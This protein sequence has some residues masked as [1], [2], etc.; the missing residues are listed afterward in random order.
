MT[1]APV[2]T[3][4]RPL[5][6][7]YTVE[8]GT[9]YLSGMQ[10][11]VRLPL[12][13]RRHDLAAGRD[14]A[15]FIS[16]YEGSP[17]AGYDL[18][19]GR[20]QALLDEYG[21]VFMPGLNEELAANAVQGSQLAG[22]Q[23]TAKQD[24]VIGIWYGKAP[25]LDRAS[26][27]IR[28]AN[29]G[30]AHP[31]GGALVLVG[32]DSTAKS[33]T[34]PSSSEIAM[35]ELGLPVLSP[36]DP[37][38][39]LFLG[40]H[41]LAM[42]RFSGLYV[43]LKIATNVADGSATTEVAPDLVTPVIPDNKV[44][45]FPYVHE[46]SAQFLQPTLSELENSLA[47]KRLVLAARYAVA[48]GLNRTYGATG[49]ARVGIVTAGASYLD[50]RQALARLGLSEEELEARGIRLLRLGVVFPLDAEEIIAFADGLDEIVVVEEKRSF[51]ESGIKDILYGRPDAP[52][53]SGK[54]TM[55]RLPLLRSDA[56]LDPEQITDALRRRLSEH[57]ALPA[58]AEAGT[59]RPRPTTIA[60]PL[61]ARTPY[62]CSGCPHNRSTRAPDGSLVGAG[63]GC[64]GMAA[65]M[66]SDRVGEVIGLS[67]MGGEGGPWIGMSPFVEAPHLLQN[68]GDGTFHHSGSLAIRAA[69]A[70]QV[71]I[72]YKIL[73][74]SAVAMT[75]GQDA[76]G[77]MTV[78]EIV[79]E[80]LAEGVAR[81]VITTEEPHR[82]RKIRLP[83]GVEVRHR[84]RLI[85]TQQELAKVPGVT[86]LI[87]D[88]ECATELRRKRKRKL[89][90]EP[91]E[92]AFINER[93][94]EGC[95][96]CGSKSNC[97]SVQ[98]VGTEY[99]RKTAIHQASC[100]KDYSCLDGDCPSFLTVV[101]AASGN[102]ATPRSTVA[103][104]DD[105]MLPDPEL[106]VPAD[107][108]GLRITGIGGTGVVTVSQII[109]TA[110]SNSGRYV[111]TLDQTGLAQKGGAVV[112][113]VKI[114]TRPVARS[115]KIAR[116]EADLYLGCDVL[117]AAT[118]TYLSVASPERTV[119][120]VSTA[121]VPTGAMVTDTAVAFP[122]P[123]ETAGRIQA[124]VRDEAS[125]YI[126]AR[127]LTKDLFD[128]DQF[129][130][131]FLVGV[132]FQAGALPLEAARIEE[133][134][135]LN[136]VQV[137]RN[138]QAFRRGRQFAAD[139]AALLADL[140]ALTASDDAPAEPSAE[141][142]RIAGSVQ[143]A[144][145]GALA[146]LVVRRVDDLIAYQNVRY[147]ERYAAL[148]ERARAAEESAVPGSEE[149]ALATAQHLH[150]LM[151]YKDEYEVAR[152]SVDPALRH[153]LEAQFGPGYKASY[154][155][156]PPV[157]R[158]LGMK[159]KLTLGPWFRIV[160]TVL[161]AL[162]GLRGTPFDVFGLARVRRAERALVTEYDALIAELAGAITAE[163]HA[164]AVEIA[165]LPDLVRGYEE[166]K[167][168]NIERY[169]ERL[170]ELRSS[171]LQPP[172]RTAAS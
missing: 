129:A 169:H 42:S 133:A 163:N 113:D 33:S 57:V 22:A 10:A 107:Q 31:E 68:M 20:Q 67:Q 95:G 88:Q 148:V 40:V 144:A 121:E 24:G 96:D 63:I 65:L 59:A 66:P 154:R 142:V 55:N 138:V 92:R 137:P 34:V 101:P 155:L 156:H 131:V 14:T 97:L 161:Y 167:E 17:L 157:L 114:S 3:A 30:G 146:A 120:V 45:G 78:P 102:R 141:A 160:F 149:F 38:D 12:D 90:V 116:G 83:G 143:A 150:K 162:R 171:F 80:L 147:A 127:Q 41:G 103:D 74:N 79:S 37:Q 69:L 166:I 18:E 119:A 139:P 81:I 124:R 123:A 134:I 46:V 64:S 49:E 72:T 145:D 172:A 27:A 104:L 13:L 82:Y 126:D 43:G 109:A 117:V 125:R 32:D 36:A 7:R 44:A 50:V 51:V 159:K 89:V 93:V 111:R 35:A 158:A 118:D 6:E 29:L 28:H 52:A 25:G 39:I 4:A 60:L 106:V 19:L 16:G 23:P 54:T 21:V 122:E 58:P 8:R 48:N 115:N 100:N 62:F 26:D 56:D 135:S 70:G 152:L 86:V 76:V 112:S 91:V 75:G 105:G 5:V 9:V 170:A 136:G 11:L 153:A 85:E 110:A 151:A 47:T 164:L 99:G 108:F 98:P 132:A 71:N 94:C 87:H 168:R 15:C 61:L 2:D 140:A 165:E 77:A 1:Q 130:N 53:V 128:D 73:Y 84:D